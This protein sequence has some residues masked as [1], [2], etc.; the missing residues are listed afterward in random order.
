MPASATTNKRLFYA[1]YG[2]GFAPT[3]SSPTYIG[4]SGVQSIGLNTTFKLDPIFQLGELDIF[5]QLEDIPNVELSIEQVIGDFALACNLATPNAT[6]AATLISRFSNGQCTAAIGYYAD[7]ASAASGV[8]KEELVTMSGMYVSSI[9][10]DFPVEGTAKHSLTLVGNHK[11]W[12]TALTTFP[13]TG[14]GT[15]APADIVRRQ[16]LSSANL[17]SDLPDTGID[18]N[19]IQSIKIS[20]DFGRPE[21]FQLGQKAPYC[22]Y[23]EFPTEVT[24]AIEMMELRGDFVTANPTGDTSVN[25]EI[26]FTWNKGLVLNLGT[27]NRLL[28]VTSQGGDTGGGNRMTTYNYRNYNTLTITDPFLA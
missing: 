14:F 20:S 17:P 7:T 25:R 16:N 18:G 1:T 10:F 9:S 5:E 13:N 15:A 19:K 23:M 24:C 27:Q 22:R 21:I 3:G 4:V 28:S 11:E 6:G 26:S 8:G 12:G 2:I